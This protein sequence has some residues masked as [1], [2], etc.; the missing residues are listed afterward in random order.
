MSM[1][2]YKFSAEQ[3]AH[4][5][6]KLL[7]L[8]PN[9]KQV[10]YRGKT[11]KSIRDLYYQCFFIHFPNYFIFRYTMSA[12]IKLNSSNNTNGKD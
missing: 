3:K 7:D 5:K 6:K 9:A 8:S 10:I 11:Y 2:N 1:T 4:M 12:A